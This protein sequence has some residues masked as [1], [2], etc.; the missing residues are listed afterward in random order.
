MTT[1]ATKQNIFK[2]LNIKFSAH[3]E[4]GQLTV[5]NNEAAISRAIRNLVLTNK[6]ERL[7]QPTIYSNLPASL[8]ENFGALQAQ[9]LRNAIRDVINS[10]EPRAELLNITLRDDLDRNGID[11]SIIYRPINSSVPVTIN[12]LLE[13]VR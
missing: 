7:F 1:R 10:Y 6:Y 5:L 9:V 12:L 11:V 2:D 4:T 8:F 13:R 3:P